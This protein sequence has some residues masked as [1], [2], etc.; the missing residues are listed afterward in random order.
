MRQH[1][2][3]I[4][5]IVMPLTH[6][7]IK[8]LTFKK[9]QKI[10][11]YFPLQLQQVVSSFSLIISFT[12]DKTMSSARGSSKLFRSHHNPP[13][14]QEDP[15]QRLH[16]GL[17]RKD[18]VKLYVVK[19]WFPNLGLGPTGGSQPEEEGCCKA[20]WVLLPTFS[21]TPIAP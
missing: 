7:C 19:Q 18:N 3:I 2:V 11:S 14:Y 1:R 20:Q 8:P 9:S 12:Y 21:C 15:Q 13:S 17:Y 16:G 4:I 6:T 5:I 10:T